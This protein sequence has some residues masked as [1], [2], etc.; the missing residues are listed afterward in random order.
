MV[1]METKRPGSVTFLLVGIILLVLG[2]GLYAT[3][4]PVVQCPQTGGSVHTGS[5]DLPGICWRCGMGT[6]FVDSRITLA[7]RL[8]WKPSPEWRAKYSW[9]KWE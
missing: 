4:V 9:H 1:E 3:F 8:F 2:A 6:A 5:V 7:N